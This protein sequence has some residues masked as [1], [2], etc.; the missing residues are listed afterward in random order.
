MILSSF[1]QNNP[2]QP[3]EKHAYAFSNAVS[4]C[5][6]IAQFFPTVKRFR[7]AFTLYALQNGADYAILIKAFRKEQ[8]MRRKD[9]EITDFSEILKI[10]DACEILLW[11]AVSVS[12]SV[13]KKRVPL[14]HST[15]Q[16]WHHSV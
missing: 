9:R 14:A 6:I 7:Q 1:T 12:T 13:G 3:S 2:N 15:P 11:E 10:V 5:R 8:L 4:P 16:F